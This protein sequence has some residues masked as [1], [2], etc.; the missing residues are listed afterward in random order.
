MNI[1][2]VGVAIASVSLLPMVVFEALVAWRFSTRMPV[3][4]ALNS[5]RPIEP[6]HSAVCKAFGKT[7]AKAVGVRL[8]PGPPRTHCELEMTGFAFSYV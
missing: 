2:T 7:A 5:N 6:V 4:G 3:D 8:P 1:G